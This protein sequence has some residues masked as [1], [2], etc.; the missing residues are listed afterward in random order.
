M[1]IY[2]FSYDNETD[3]LNSLAK[4]YGITI[5]K[6]SSK[7]TEIK[8]LL[9]EQ[10]T[11]QAD[12]GRYVLCIRLLLDADPE[13]KNIK[14]R[15]NYYHHCSC[16]GSLEWFKEGLLNG[17]EG[18]KAFVTKVNLLLPN[19]LS[20]QVFEELN[21]RLKQRTDGELYF[22]KGNTGVF[23]Y[24]RLDEACNTSTYDFPEV[25]LDL[26]DRANSNRLKEE[27][28]NVL[29]PTV[30]KFY[31]DY[32]KNDF[33]WIIFNYWKL[34]CQKFDERATHNSF[35]IGRGKTIP[36]EQIEKIFLI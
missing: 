10:A 16:D 36:F 33:D 13:P 25:F 22:R 35:D 20:E 1:E 30:V 27:L 6:I 4:Y 23:A 18:L 29:K 5:E 2:K 9:D 21:N 8:E 28:K 32:D 31:K 14:L 15:V 34:V 24:S 19:L 11:L 17:T 26:S 7:L 12:S 3:A